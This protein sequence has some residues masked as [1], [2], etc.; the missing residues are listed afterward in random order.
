MLL[1]GLWKGRLRFLA[2]T[3]LVY[4]REF[5]RFDFTNVSLLKPGGRPPLRPLA[6][7]AINP[8]FVRSLIISLSNSAREA[9]MLNVNLPVAVLVLME[10]C[11]LSNPTCS[12]SI[13]ET[14]SIKTFNDLPSLS[15][16][17]TM[18]LSPFL[19]VS[20]ILISSGLSLDLDEIFSSNINSQPVF[21]K[22]SICKLKFWSNVLTLAYPIFIKKLYKQR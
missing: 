16:F 14:K 15:N 3:Y 2:L 6:R 18:T 1:L 8:T 4:H 9:N 20:N 22:A 10:S 19:S 17:H 21:F 11:M 7:A 5:H 13:F 12:F